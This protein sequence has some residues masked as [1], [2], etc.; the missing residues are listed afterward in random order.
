ML[1]TAVE[2][3]S[4]FVNEALT[5]LELVSTT[6]VK[7]HTSGA[8]GRGREKERKR[9]QTIPGGPQKDKTGTGDPQKNPKRV[10]EWALL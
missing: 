10:L 7:K 2:I 4:R 1:T 3:N 6:V 9:I 5:K 8:A